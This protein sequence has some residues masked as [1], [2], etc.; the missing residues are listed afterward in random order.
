MKKFKL[1]CK[2]YFFLHAVFRAGWDAA[3]IFYFFQDRTKRPERVRQDID[4]AF[5]LFIE[6]SLIAAD[7]EAEALAILNKAK[8]DEQSSN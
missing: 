1:Q 5:D 6:E 8:W 3:T 4:S 2:T 7:R